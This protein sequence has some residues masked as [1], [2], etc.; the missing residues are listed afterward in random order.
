MSQSLPLLLIPDHIGYVLTDQSLSVVRFLPQMANYVE[1][2]ELLAIAEDLR[3]G[4]PELYGLENIFAEIFSGQ[5]QQFSVKAINRTLADGKVVYLDLYFRGYLAPA[6]DGN[7]SEAFLIMFVEDVTDKMALEQTLVQSNN[8]TSLLMTALENSKQY[9][10]TIIE[11]MAEALVVTN[12]QGE[13][14]RINPVTEQMLGYAEAELLGRSLPEILGTAEAQLLDYDALILLV[15]QNSKQRVE[16]NAIHKSGERMILSFS[17][18]RVDQDMNVS[19]LIYVGR[20]VTRD[21]LARKRLSTQYAIASTLSEASS[22]DLVTNNALT[23]VCEQ[24][25]F[26]L[27]ELWVP[28]IPSEIDPI[29]NPVI[30]AYPP[31]LAYLQRKHVVAPSG[32]QIAKFLEISSRVLLTPNAGLAGRVWSHKIPH[33]IYDLGADPDFG[34]QSF[35]HQVGLSSAF[36]FPIVADQEVLGVMTFFASQRRSDDPEL[37]QMVGS[38]GQQLGQYIRRKQTED[39]LKE[40]QRQTESLLLN[41]LPES[42][43]TQLRQSGQTIAKQFD[44]AT[45]L[46]ADIV[47]FT[48]FASGL[49]PIEVVEI[50]NTIFSDFDTLTEKYQLEKI[51]TIGD[52]YMVV[53]GLPEPRPDHTQA[54]A[55][56]ALDM[57]QALMDFN[58]QTNNTL[59]LRIGINSGAVVAGVIGQKKFIYDLWGDT[60][61]I[62]S[63]MESHGLPDRIQCS[64]ATYLEL[65]DRNYEWET[66]GEIPIK[67]KGLMRTYFLNGRTD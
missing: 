39:A 27:G 31:A 14:L 61:N 11:S 40:Q 6:S 36:A 19:E 64:H 42:I 47:G 20:D 67:G 12:L 21:R 18:S 7:T 8:E 54:I 9:A 52:S 59:Q 26:D 37:L 51:K 45:V 28:I 4:F 65:L 30:Q 63:R 33:W 3:E 32:A 25:D 16:V 38:V 53:G 46:F 57:R 15:T 13:I 10:N 62:A 35:A 2:P 29:Q 23:A 22:V 43:A 48:Q 66:R 56:M 49:S 60:V 34:E 41:I 44:S 17:C 5:R 24:L 55:E 1:A 58:Q 50:L